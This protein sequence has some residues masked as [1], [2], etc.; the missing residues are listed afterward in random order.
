MLLKVPIKMRTRRILYQLQEIS[1]P[2][3]KHREFHMIVYEGKEGNR[4]R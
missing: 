4:R 1:P 3:A 2:S